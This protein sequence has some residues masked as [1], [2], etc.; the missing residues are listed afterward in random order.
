MPF[1]QS[2]VTLSSLLQVNHPAIS[3]LLV[4]LRCAIAGWNDVPKLLRFECRMSRR[5]NVDAAVIAAPYENHDGSQVGN[6]ATQNV[7]STNSP[8]YDGFL[9]VSLFD[10]SVSGI[11]NDRDFL[12]ICESSQSTMINY[13]RCLEDK[14]LLA[15]F[16]WIMVVLGVWGC[17]DT[18]TES[19]TWRRIA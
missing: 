12:L 2:H 5:V 10:I 3:Q 14:L 16:R 9:L 18:W 8:S 19:M 11:L 6:I 15:I 7:L 13:K 1:I 17:D 4:Q